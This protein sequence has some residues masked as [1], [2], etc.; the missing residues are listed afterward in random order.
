MAQKF[1]KIIYR[2]YHD[3]HHKEKRI[4]AYNIS[5]ALVQA[6]RLQHMRHDICVLYVKSIYGRCI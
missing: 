2:D 3:G 4:C 5:D 1:Y 6:K